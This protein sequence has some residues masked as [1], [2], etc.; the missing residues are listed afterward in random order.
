M[1]RAVGV[2][3]LALLWAGGMFLIVSG[4]L[5]YPDGRPLKGLLIVGGFWASIAT[6]ALAEEAAELLENRGRPR[7]GDKTRSP[8]AGRVTSARPA[9][10]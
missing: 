3:F 8:Q 7:L 1:R 9:S 5:N 2:A 4:L 10:V 6:V